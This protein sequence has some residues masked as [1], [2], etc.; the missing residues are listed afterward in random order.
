MYERM[1]I[2]LVE[3]VLIACGF[4]LVWNKYTQIEYLWKTVRNEALK[5]LT[6]TYEAI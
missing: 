5:M 6:S 1:Q 2:K 3:H 4:Y